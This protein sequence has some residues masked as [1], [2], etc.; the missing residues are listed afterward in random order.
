MDTVSLDE[1]AKRIGVNKMTIYR[2][3]RRRLVP[4]PPR[5]ARTNKRLYTLEH[6][7]ILR[8]Y[9]NSVIFPEVMGQN[10]NPAR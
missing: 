4:L 9:K 1:A 2:W 3:E 8:A 7:E 5:A 6:I 10:E